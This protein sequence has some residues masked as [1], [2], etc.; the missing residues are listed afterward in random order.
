MIIS[1]WWNFKYLYIYIFSLIQSIFSKFFTIK[2]SYFYNQENHVKNLLIL[3]ILWFIWV[4]SLFWNSN[5][6]VNGS[7]NPR[8]KKPKENKNI[9]CGRG[10]GD[11]PMSPIYPVCLTHNPLY[12]HFTELNAVVSFLCIILVIFTQTQQIHVLNPPSFLIQVFPL[13]LALN[14][15][16]IQR[17]FY[18]TTYKEV[19][20]SL[21]L[22]HTAFHVNF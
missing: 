18:I 19:P 15:K 7:Y 2:L 9:K 5:L 4:S 13:L 14:N 11:P 3:W 16:Y 12:P 22:G 8:F 20:C 10:H 6:F 21:P 1:R 17:S